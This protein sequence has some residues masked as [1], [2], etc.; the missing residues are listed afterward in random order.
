M[1]L[2]GVTK[3]DEHRRRY[4][5]AYD[6][7]LASSGVPHEERDLATRYGTT[8]VVTAGDPTRPVLVA[9]HAKNASAA[10][11]GPMLP[12]LTATHRVVLVDAITD[13]NKSRQTRGLTTPAQLAE[14]LDDVLDGAAVTSAAFL[15]ASMGS[16]M[17]AT[18]ALERPTRASAVALLCPAGVFAK[19]STRWLLGATRAVAIRPTEQKIRAFADT[20]TEADGRD[21]LRLEP[22]CH[23]ADVFVRS[24]TCFRVPLD[25]PILPVVIPPERLATITVPALVVIGA[26][27]SL[28]DGPASAAVA[29]AALPHARV[30]LLEGANHMVNIDRPAEVDRLVGAFLASLA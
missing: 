20:M 26:Q 16:F 8:H 21:R 9:L 6:A 11:W 1:R 29:R 3:S 10:M 14:W 24:G 25:R 27:E 28:A 22:W 17:T 5:A 19:M 30:E 12:L 13:Q 4:D 18:Y 23:F 2:A 15:G 7:L